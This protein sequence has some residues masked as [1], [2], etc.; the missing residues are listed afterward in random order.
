MSDRF[1]APRGTRD[2][3]GDD[4]AVRRRVLDLAREVFEPAGYGEIVTPGFEDTALFARSSGE[5]SEV[6]P[7]LSRQDIY[8]ASRA[9]SHRPAS[10]AL[11][12]RSGS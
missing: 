4:A 7:D 6:V 9:A 3:Y 1:Q 8:R 5:S 12:Q 11:P 10:V 2:W